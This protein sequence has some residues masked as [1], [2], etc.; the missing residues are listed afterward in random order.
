MRMLAVGS[1]FLAIALATALHLG[2]ARNVYTMFM[3]CGMPAAAITVARNEYLIECL[4]AAPSNY[5]LDEIAAALVCDGRFSEA[6][7]IT[8]MV[9]DTN[10][11]EGRVWAQNLNGYMK[12]EAGHFRESEQS[13]RQAMAQSSSYSAREGFACL[14][15]CYLGEGEMSEAS[16][17][18]G[19]LSEFSPN[20]LPAPN[21]MMS[22]VLG[23]YAGATGNLSAQRMWYL[24]SQKVNPRKFRLDQYHYV[25]VARKYAQALRQL[26]YDKLANEWDQ[27]AVDL[28]AHFNLTDME[29][30]LPTM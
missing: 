4:N 6:A 5:T 7:P 18:A 22:E 3:N 10:K 8:Q 11:S 29:F 25:R 21:A 9:L 2:F 24:H 23:D 1:F 28:S 30:L 20:S 13:F 26:G 16:T 12:L 17:I 27:K 14:L 15:A 19:A